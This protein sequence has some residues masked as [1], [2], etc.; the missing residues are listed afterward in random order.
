MRTTIAAAIL[1]MLCAD[2]SAQSRVQTLTECGKSAGYAYY[3]SGGLVPADKSGLR[4]DAIDGGRII[5]NLT[6]NDLDILIKDASGTTQSVKQ[7]GGKIFVRPSNNDLIALMV[8][9]EHESATTELYV[10]QIDRRGD[11]TVVSTLART[12][13]KINKISLMTAQCRGPR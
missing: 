8:M 11:G 2:V 6:D 1:L 4:Q 10:F 5:L 3:F 12:A 13:G 7:M 9:Y